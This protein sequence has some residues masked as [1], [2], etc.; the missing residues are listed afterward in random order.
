LSVFQ[1]HRKFHSH[2][3]EVRAHQIIGQQIIED[4]Y[5]LTGGDPRGRRYNPT[6]HHRRQ[7]LDEFWVAHCR[8]HGALIVVLFYL[9]SASAIFA[10]MTYMHDMYEIRYHS[11][12][13]NK[14]FFRICAGAVAA[15]FGA[16]VVMRHER[17]DLE[18]VKVTASHAD[19]EDAAASLR[20]EY[21]VYTVDV[22]QW[23]QLALVYLERVAEAVGCWA[24]RQR[25]AAAATTGLAASRH[26]LH[27]DY[28]TI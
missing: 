2:E 6:D 26:P 20:S 1:V 4:S 19:A 14:I 18:K 28:G 27:R 9:G 15:T 23:C 17:L 24:R 3:D 16:V 5:L 13:A 25:A 8:H 11:P 22:Q 10:M 7:T 12:L 21:A